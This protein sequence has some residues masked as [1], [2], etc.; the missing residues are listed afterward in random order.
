MDATASL[1]SHV[2]SAASAASTSRPRAR[3]SRG[4]FVLAAGRRC[5]PPPQAV[6]L[7]GH[8]H[9]LLL[10]RSILVSVGFTA[11]TRQPA[12]R[13]SVAWVHSGPGSNPGWRPKHRVRVGSVRVGTRFCH[14]DEQGEPWEHSRAVVLE[15]IL[16]MG[17]ICRPC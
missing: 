14:T 15:E 17:I 9:P 12:D 7:S 16:V 13:S 8:R 3:Q 5:W 10:F 6:R 11:W 2:A 4:I 1:S